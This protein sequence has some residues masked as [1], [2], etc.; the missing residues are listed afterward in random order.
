VTLAEA[1]AAPSERYYAYYTRFPQRH[2]ELLN[3]GQENEPLPE[4]ADEQENL[5]AAWRW[6]TSHVQS[7]VGL[8]ADNEA[9]TAR[10]LAAKAA[11]D[12]S[13]AMSRAA[14]RPL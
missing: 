4:I 3:T 8:H 5:W 13:G 10:L 14:T 2:I 11:S 9:G 12:V 7:R 1:R 6:A